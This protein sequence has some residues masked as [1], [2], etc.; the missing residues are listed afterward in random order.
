MIRMITIK[1]DGTDIEVLLEQE[2][3]L[4]RLRQEFNGGY[5]E[6]VPM[7]DQIWIDGERRRNV[8]AAYIDE[9][10]RSKRLP[11]NRR[12]TIAWL[13]CLSDEHPFAYVP[14]VLGNMV[15]LLKE[16]ETK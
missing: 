4:D 2:P 7:F 12:A 15:V 13:E 9:D 16:R 3:D 6:L 5:I 11:F 14:H 1:P 8:I 10:A